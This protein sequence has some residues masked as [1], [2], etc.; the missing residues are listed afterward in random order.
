M[1]YQ[2]QQKAVTS[3]T[4]FAKG[5]ITS[6]QPDLKLEPEANSNEMIYISSGLALGM[7]E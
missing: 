2:K 5:N 7:L 4:N 1:I 3:I 6:V